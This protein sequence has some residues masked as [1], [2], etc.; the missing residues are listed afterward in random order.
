MN[1]WEQ[2]ITLLRESPES[3]LQTKYKDFEKK[4]DEALSLKNKL[5]IALE[6]SVTGNPKFA[7]SNDAWKFLHDFQEAG[8]GIDKAMHEYK[9]IVNDFQQFVRDRHEEVQPAATKPPGKTFH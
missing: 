7:N 1:A 6:Q 3:E 4:M 9:E 5:Y 8:L 2:V